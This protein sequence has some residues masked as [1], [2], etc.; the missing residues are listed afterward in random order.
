LTAGL[1]S[2]LDA[3][4][5]NMLSSAILL[6]PLSDEIAFHVY[7]SANRVN[8]FTTVQKLDFTTDIVKKTLFSKVFLKI[9]HPR[10]PAART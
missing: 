6:T 5:D 1:P 2:S 10:S 8:M 3:E 7:Y 4:V 9:T